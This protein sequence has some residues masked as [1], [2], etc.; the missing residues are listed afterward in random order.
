MAVWQ[1]W[2]HRR[3]AG[4]TPTL[5][6]LVLLGACCQHMP[7]C[8]QALHLKGAAQFWLPLL[9]LEFMLRHLRTTPQIA[10]PPPPLQKHCS[11]ALAQGHRMKKPAVTHGAAKPC[12]CSYKYTRALF[13]VYTG[14]LHPLGLQ[15]AAYDV[16]LQMHPA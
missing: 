13:A 3:M 5:L 1:R 14:S 7:T 2:L 9:L 8:M 11:R 6:R 10:F 15:V 4:S 16:T 12:K